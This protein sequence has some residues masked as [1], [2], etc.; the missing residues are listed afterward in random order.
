MGPNCRVLAKVWN[1]LQVEIHG[2]HSIERVLDLTNYTNEASLLRVFAVLLVTPLPCLAITVIV[3]V[4]PL[5]DPLEGANANMMYF[6]RLFYTFLVTTFLAIHQFRISVPILSYPTIRAIRSTFVVSALCVGF[7]YGLAEMI[8]FPLPFSSMLVTP[9]WTSLVLVSVAAEWMKKIAE[10]PGSGTMVFNV[11]KLWTCEAL[12]VF[13]YPI[14][15]YIFTT[16]SDNGKTAFASLLLVMKLIMKNIIARSAVHL[17]DE[18][19]EVVVFNAEVFNALFASY[20]L[21]NSPSIWVTLEIMIFDALTMAFSLRDA[22]NVRRNL[23]HL[24]HRVDSARAQS[25]FRAKRLDRKLT[26]LS[27]ASVLLRDPVKPKASLTSPF[28]GPNTVLVT[29]CL[30]QASKNVI[31]LV[32][33]S[34]EPLVTVKPK[35][36]QGVGSASDRKIKELF[37]FA[38]VHPAPT[39][40]ENDQTGFQMRYV[41]TVQRLLYAVEFLLLL[42]Y[43]EVIV[44]LVYCEYL[45]VFNYLNLIN[46]AFR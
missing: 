12:L 17:R 21:Q 8:S 3:D 45:H 19:P 26:T 28:N 38:S 33:A 34:I 6:V 41:S 16:L 44:P 5:A 32:E 37:H 4:L 31:A 22:G 20:C 40:D 39:N 35:S 9:A 43:V 36:F 23:K 46:N 24:E 30:C 10:T 1:G 42:N 2:S 14:Y 18:M 29:P 7:L 25:T 13:I 15:Y 27:R 11:V